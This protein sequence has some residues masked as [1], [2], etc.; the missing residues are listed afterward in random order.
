MC[1]KERKR[2]ADMN[3]SNWGSIGTGSRTGGRQSIWTGLTHSDDRPVCVARQATERGRT[4]GRPVDAH[5]GQQCEYLCA[6][7]S[8][9]V[10]DYVVDD[11]RT[12]GD[13][14]QREAQTRG[15]FR[16]GQ[17]DR[18]GLGVGHG[19]GGSLEFAGRSGPLGSAYGRRR[20]SLG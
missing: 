3:V 13:A 18:D 1:E 14:E 7:G 10:L 2:A 12:V 8:R 11:R 5:G 19:L 20:G 17:R 16:T 6:F 4:G 9:R 15:H